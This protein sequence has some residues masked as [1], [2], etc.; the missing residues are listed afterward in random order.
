MKT[1]HE[2][3][4][5]AGGKTQR[6]EV[7]KHVQKSVAFLE[8][9][10]VFYRTVHVV[11][12]VPV[13]DRHG[14]RGSRRPGCV[15]EDRRIRIRQRGGAYFEG[16]GR[17]FEWRRYCR[18]PNFSNLLRNLF[19]PPGKDD[20]G[21]IGMQ[22]VCRNGRFAGLEIERNEAPPIFHTAII[23]ARKTGEFGRRTASRLPS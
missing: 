13:T 15:K 6:M 16:R 7:G 21:D 23:R 8:V 19:H 14:L 20:P 2:R 10:E 18:N 11:Q 1:A 5:A 9:C 12:K 22:K 17:S 3:E 4:K